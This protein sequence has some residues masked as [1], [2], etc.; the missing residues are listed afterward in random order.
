V[1][2][3]ERRL[4]LLQRASAIY[5]LIAVTPFALPGVA[6]WEIAQLHETAVRFSI[7]GAFPA[8]SPT[9]LFFANVFG[10]FT[11]TWSVLRLRNTEPRYAFYDVVLRFAFA[12]TMLFYVVAYD[13]TRILLLFAGFEV[14]WGGLQ[15]FG[16][17]NR[18]TVP[19]LLADVGGYDAK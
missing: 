5:D 15:C 19:R 1:S 7:S 14:F 17:V 9:H 16:Y 8:F 3:A 12:S 2:P 11:I 10:I 6:G 13:V 18:R 4:R